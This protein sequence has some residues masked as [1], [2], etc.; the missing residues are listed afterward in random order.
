MPLPVAFSAG[1][2]EQELR[3]LRLNVSPQFIIESSFVDSVWQVFRLHP[4]IE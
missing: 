2:V 4:S 1:V 3:S